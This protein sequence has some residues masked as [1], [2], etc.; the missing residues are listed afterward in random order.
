MKEV[1]ETVILNV[2]GPVMGSC[3]FPIEPTPSVAVR[4]SVGFF[5]SESST[6]SGEAPMDVE[7][8]ENEDNTDNQSSMH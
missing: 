2:S 8:D 3:H 5:N 4:P 1:H 7:K 6:V